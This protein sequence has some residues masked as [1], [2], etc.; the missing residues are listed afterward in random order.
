MNSDDHID[1]SAALVSSHFAAAAQSATRQGD[2]L[3]R[4][5]AKAAERIVQTFLQNHKLVVFA[6]HHN[7][8]DG[9]S[10]VARMLG[11]LEQARPALPALRLNAPSLASEH[12]EGTSTAATEFQALGNAGD[13]LLVFATGCQLPELQS[14]SAVAQERAIEVIWFGPARDESILSVRGEGD[15][16]VWF[17]EQRIIRLLELQRIAVHA[18]ADAIDSLLLGDGA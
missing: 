4:G 8:A 5:I 2:A 11:Q 6:P 12:A 7:R 9:D 17:D 1:A 16:V 13:V 14:L 15:L 10:M 18:L 3:S